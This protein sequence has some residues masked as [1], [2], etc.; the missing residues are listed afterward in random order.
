M[1]ELN[2]FDTESISG[3]SFSSGEKSGEAAGQELRHA[4]DGALTA[5]QIGKWLGL[6]GDLAV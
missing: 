5:I 6:F 3:G 1:I 4:F 2:G